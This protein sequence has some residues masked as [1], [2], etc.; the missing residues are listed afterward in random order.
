MKELEFAFGTAEFPVVSRHSKSVSGLRFFL[1]A[2]RREGVCAAGLPSAF[3]TPPL[4]ETCCGGGADGDFAT[5]G[6][7]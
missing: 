7:S 4:R 5:A 3:V 6:R 2:P 1:K